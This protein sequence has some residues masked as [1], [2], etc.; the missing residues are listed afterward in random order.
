MCCNKTLGYGSGRDGSG[1]KN[2]KKTQKRIPLIVHLVQF[3]PKTD[4]LQFLYFNK[5]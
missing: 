2:A 1:T 3:R 5:L 4:Q